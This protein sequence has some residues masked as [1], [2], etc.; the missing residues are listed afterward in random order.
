MTIN[1]IA[2]GSSGNLYEIID[3]ENNCILIE[4]GVD[5]SVFAKYRESPKV[6]EMCIITHAHSDH[7]FYA[8]NYEMICPVHKW[9]QKVDSQSFKAFGY[10]VKHGNV[11]NYA[12]LI[13]SLVDNEFLFFATDLEYEKDY[14]DLIAKD[15][16]FFYV[17][18][19][20]VECNY[21]DYLY[22]LADRNQ[23]I[24]CDN[25][26]S[27]NDLVRFLRSLKINDFKLITI[28]GSNRLSGDDYTRKILQGKFPA[29]T[30]RVS[31]GVK[32]GVKNIFKL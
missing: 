1:V 6:P 25:H 7:A 22:H 17:K 11:L 30:I 31:T 26:F 24:G 27:D 13:K 29:G 14:L 4:A 18:K 16:R 15:L 12:Y 10:R 5:R 9:E 23:R 2:T 19:L 28:H 3:S 32:N 20:L 8:N 21:N